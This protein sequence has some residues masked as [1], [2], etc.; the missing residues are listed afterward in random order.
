MALRFKKGPT[1]LAANSSDDESDPNCDASQAHYGTKQK[2][3][4]VI[5]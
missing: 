2:K 1:N 4:T 3:K 5:S